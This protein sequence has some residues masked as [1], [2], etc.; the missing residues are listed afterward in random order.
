MRGRN[1]PMWSPLD[2]ERAVVKP[3]R[4]PEPSAKLPRKGRAQIIGIPINFQKLSGCGL[5]GDGPTCPRSPADTDATAY[6]ARGDDIDAAQCR[7]ALLWLRGDYNPI[8]S[9]RS[10]GRHLGDDNPA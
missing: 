7:A 5:R 4:G 2:S 1:A 9:A 6:Q 10:R 3:P 8:R